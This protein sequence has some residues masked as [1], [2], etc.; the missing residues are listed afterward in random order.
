MK[1]LV[2]IIIIAAIAVIPLI[3]A[4]S[5]GAC[6]KCGYYGCEHDMPTCV[7]GTTNHDWDYG[8]GY[9]SYT[10]LKCGCNVIRCQVIGHSWYEEEYIYPTCVDNGRVGYRCDECDAFYYKTIPATGHR[11]SSADWVFDPWNNGDMTKCAYGHYCKEC[12]A[13]KYATK[14]V[15]KGKSKQILPKKFTKKTKKIKVSYNKKKVSATKKGKI[16]GKKRGAATDITWRIKYK[17][18]KAWES[19]IVRVKVQ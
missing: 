15:K 11:W 18:A 2:R 14:A 3:F 8:S 16:K 6:E 5:S 1:I 4:S 19:F 10:C 17:G 12:V 9:S 13:F 7:D